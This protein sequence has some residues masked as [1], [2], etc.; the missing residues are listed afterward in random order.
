MI[1]IVE[2]F[3]KN[4]YSKIFNS[5]NLNSISA[6]SYRITH[7]KL[8]K[9]FTSD[10]SFDRVL[11]I[12]AGKGE[13][14]KFIRHK[15]NNYVMADLVPIEVDIDDVRVEKVAFDARQIPFESNFFD[16]TLMMCVL[17]HIRDLYQALLEIKRVTKS[18]GVITIFLPHDPLLANRLNRK[19]FINRGI[20]KL[21]FSKYELVNA[22]EHNNHYHS[23][24][25][26]VKDVFEG[27]EIYTKQYPFFVKIPN[28]NLFSII[29]IY[30]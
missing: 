16:R 12:G 25:S 10:I 21:G 28:L 4:Y 29:K 23:I 1:P 15:F 27:K 22:I 11:E 7:K 19:I 20:K 5:E 9:S 14:L 3:Y 13:H 6:I 17:H 18:G 24:M 8:E 2:E 26:Q 30:P